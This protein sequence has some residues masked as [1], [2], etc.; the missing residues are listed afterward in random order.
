MSRAL[1]ATA[2][3]AYHSRPGLPS[4]GAAMSTV[5][6]WSV[7]EPMVHCG[8]VAPSDSLSMANLLEVSD[9]GAGAEVFEDAVGALTV[10]QLPDPAV[11]VVE[12]AEHDRVGRAH[13]LA[14]GLDLAIL[15][16]DL[17]VLQLAGLD[18]GVLGGGDPLHAQA[19]L[20]HHAA[21]PHRD[22][23]VEHEAPDRIGH[24][25]IE[26]RIVCVVVP[27]EPPDFVRAVVGA[28]PCSDTAVVDLLIEPLGA[29]GGGEH[30]THGLARSVAAVL[31]HHRLVHR[32]RVV[33]RA[34]VV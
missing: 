26:P 23:R 31:A 3:H 6:W 12:I 7:G 30:R 24:V 13:L 32:A 1:P 5:I 16:L 14:G 4:I 34:V 19:A 21:R 18:R 29:R 28:I 25:V 2:K 33:L 15:Q 27:V 10:H 9:V 20:L 11:L 22:I 17:A 8:S